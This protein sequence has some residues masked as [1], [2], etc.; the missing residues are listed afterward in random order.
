MSTHLVKHHKITKRQMKEDSLVTAAF[1]A[2]EVWERFGKT[3]LIVAGALALVG[4]LLFFI[5]RTRAQ[6]DQRARADLFRAMAALSQGD[7][8]SATPM[9]REIIDNS[10]GTNAARDAMLLMGDASMAQ[11]NPKEAATW[12]QKFVD[13][14]GDKELQRAG[15]LGLGAALEDEGSFAPAADAYAKAAERGRTDNER[16]R[17]LLSE[18]RSLARAGQAPKAVALYR[19]IAAM[20]GA[21]VP[22]RDAANVHLGELSVTT[23][24]AP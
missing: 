23:P 15:Y 6:A 24:T 12:Y 7:A 9:L 13:K 22:I 16:G 8:A 4:L 11:H 14:A 17:A 19:S 21:E 18:A 5:G 10:P 1:R 20:A 3:I 2:T